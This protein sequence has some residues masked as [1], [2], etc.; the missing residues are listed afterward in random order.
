MSDILIVVVRYFG[1]IKLGIPGLIRAYRTSSADAIAN[2]RIVEKVAARMFRVSFGYMEMNGVMK[3]VKEL[4]LTP[5][6]Q[7]F[8]MAC[9]LDVAVRLSAA[10]DFIARLSGLGGCDV[11]EL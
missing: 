2:A 8:G 3:I 9:S 6:N 11:T 7:D 5:C 1:G 4:G 10:D